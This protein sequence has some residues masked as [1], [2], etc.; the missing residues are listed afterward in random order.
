MATVR[1][2]KDLAKTIISR[3]QGQFTVRREALRK[4]IAQGFE[5]LKAQ[6]FEDLL[7]TVLEQHG[8]PRD[9]YD[10]IPDGWCHTTSR[11]KAIRLNNVDSE[12]LPGGNPLGKNIKVPEC[13]NYMCESLRM[14]H[15]RLQPYSE[16]AAQAN[17]QLR[18]LACE[19]METKHM[20]NSL[21]AQAG[22]L[23]QALDVW[24]HLMEL[25]PDWA[26]EKHNRPTEK[27]QKSEIVAIDTDKL[28]GAI[29]AGKMAVAVLNR[30]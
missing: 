17:E 18:L 7:T 1:L 20:A 4:H 2:T 19:E 26:V 16:Y 5:P 15:P 24:P 14:D 22:S 23:K 6:Y 3:L 8:M 29:V 9:I 21:L 25:L 10:S 28:T 30:Q 12:E 27:R 11:L 13:M